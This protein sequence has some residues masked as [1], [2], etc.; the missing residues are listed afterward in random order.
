MRVLLLLTVTIAAGAHANPAQQANPAQDVTPGSNQV[1][2]GQP[3]PV[4]RVTVV[5]K[6]TKAVN[7]RHRGGATKI[8]FK[9]TALMP[10]ANGEAK[11]ESKQGYL[12]IEVELDDLHPATQYGSEY[13][14]YVLW[15]ITPEGRAQNLGEFI[16]NGNRSKLNVTTELQAFGLIVTAEPYFGVT[17]PSD[18]VVMENEL[19]PDTRGAFD[20]VDAKYELLKRGQ[21]TMNVDPSSVQPIAMTSASK[22][23][24]LELYEARNAIRIAKWAGADKYA[25]D[26]FNKAQQSLARAEQYLERK[27]GKRPIAMMSREAVQTAEDAR[28]IAIKRQEEERLANERKAAAEREAAA[29]AKAAEEAR[30]RAEADRRRAQAEED[31]L[32]AERA[33]QAALL[34]KQEAEAAAARAAQE[35][36]AADAAR[37]RM[38]AEAER[39]R[40]AAEEANRLR[41]RAEDE[42]TQLREQIRKQLSMILETRD[43][44]RGLIVNMSDVLFDFNKYTLKQDARE[45]LAKMSGIVL[46]HP[47]LKLAIEGH[48]DSIGSDEYNQKLSEQRA[49]AVRD[50][51][52]EQ[53]VPE[54]IATGFGETRPIA[55]NDN[56]AGR[57]Q[58]RRVEIV[59]S[60]DPIGTDPAASMNSTPQQ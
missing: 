46:A 30:Q 25:A 1:Q 37:L 19:R 56:A 38:E 6:S 50:Y 54:P 36:A 48:T 16:L 44:A 23:T 28:L 35:R 10:R 42:K 51:L 26:T 41:R 5:S 18:V 2:S 9:G 21:Y 7:Y 52:V 13:L 57:Q 39:A 17:Q 45:K 20:I 34:A 55:S 15:A 4:Y 59:V 43:S 3:M 47:G 27:A 58:N 11:V 53:G 8:D 31:R 49:G 14:T 22:N 32:A 60:G 40:L 29:K 33:Q 24:P 12:E